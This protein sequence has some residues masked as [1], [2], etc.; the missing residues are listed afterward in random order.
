MKPKPP[1]HSQTT[2]APEEEEQQQPIRLSVNTLLDGVF[3]RPGAALPYNELSEVP[4]MA[5][6]IAGKIS[7][8]E[9]GSFSKWITLS[10]A[11]TSYA[12]YVRQRARLE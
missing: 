2:P 1:F 8:R 9:S 5:T 4:Q 7:A 6:S 10:S 12:V 3:Y 11:P